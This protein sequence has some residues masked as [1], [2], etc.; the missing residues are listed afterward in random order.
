LW[1]GRGGGLG[2]GGGW[3]VG[4]GKQIMIS[5][6]SAAVPQGLYLGSGVFNYTSVITADTAFL[7]IFFSF[8]V[9]PL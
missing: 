9:N 8:L 2:G 4:W 5:S 6:L 3:F 7:L 1:G